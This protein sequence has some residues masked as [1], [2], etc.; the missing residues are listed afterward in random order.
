MAQLKDLL[1]TGAS[2]LLGDIYANKI[3]I[4]TINAPTT[5]AGTVYG[6]GNNGQVLKSDGSGVYWGVEN[7]SNIS[8]NSGTANKIAYYSG[9][10]T[11]SAASNL[12]IDNTITRLTTTSGTP[13]SFRVQSTDSENGS[14]EFGLAFSSDGST[15]GLYDYTSGAT[16]WYVS[17]NDDKKLVLKSE[18]KD[19]YLPNQ[20]SWLV[21]AGNGTSTG[22]GN[23]N[24]PVYV[25][26]A[27]IATAV[28]SINTTLIAAAS[29]AEAGL[30][31][32]DMVTK[33]NTIDT[34][35]NNYI[36]PTASNTVLGGVKIGSGLTISSTGVLSTTNN[37]A[38]YRG[39]NATATESAPA[40][41]DGNTYDFNSSTTLVG[42]IGFTS[43]ADPISPSSTLYGSLLSLPG[44]TS[45]SGY[46]AQLL[47]GSISGATGLIRLRARR[48]VSS[49]TWTPFNP[50][51][52]FNA[53]A[54]N[55]ITSNGVVIADGSIGGIKTSDIIVDAA[56]SAISATEYTISANGYNAT[57]TVSALGYDWNSLSFSTPDNNNIDT[58]AA[59][60]PDGIVR[61]QA[62]SSSKAQ[63]LEGTRPISAGFHLY[64]LEGYNSSYHH[65]F[66]LSSSKSIYHRFG[67]KNDMSSS[68][69][70]RFVTIQSTTT[71]SATTGSV[72]QW[73]AVGGATTPV[74]VSS[75]GNVVACNFSV[76]TSVPATAVFTDT[77]YSAATT[78]TDGLMTAAM[79]NQLNNFNN[80][81]L[82]TASSSV[83]GGVKIGSDLNI[84]NT[85]VLSVSH[86]A[87]ADGIN[88]QST[89]N[90]IACFSNTAGT[91]KSI[92]TA[93]GAAYATAAN[94]VLTFGTLPVTEGG[95]GLTAAPSL[96]VNLAVNT[97][98]NVFSA[99]PRPGVTG[100]L[101]LA[102]G[103]LG[104]TDVSVART[105]LGLG[106]LAIKDSL[107]ASDIPDIA[108]TK[109]TGT[110]MA[111]Q[112]P[113]IDL[114]S[115]V[116]GI[117][118]IKD[119][120]TSAS[121]PYVA[122]NNLN[123][124][125]VYK[126]VTGIDDTTTNT[127]LIY[128]DTTKTFNFSSTK[129]FVGA[130]GFSSFPH[131]VTGVANYGSLLALPGVATTGY[132]AELLLS[133]ISGA[134]NYPTLS[135]RRQASTGTWSPWLHIG[136]GNNG[137]VYCPTSSTTRAK[138]G[139]CTN[140]VLK[141][142]SYYMV[143][144]ENDNTYSS[145]YFTLNVNGTGAKR[146]YI[147]GTT[148]GTSNHTLPAGDYLVWYSGNYYYF[149]T[150]SAMEGDFGRVFGASG[151]AGLYGPTLPS[152]SEG[153]IFFQT[154][155]TT[156]PAV[157]QVNTIAATANSS[158][159]LIGALT[160]GVATPYIA[161]ANSNGTKNKN[162]VRFNGSTGVL[163]GAAWNDYAEFRQKKDIVDI[164]YG[165]VV[166]E[167]GDDTVSLSTERLQPCGQ[168]ISDTYGFILGPEENAL[169][170]A[171]CGRVLAYP[172]EDR[173][174]FD[175]GDAVCTG[176][177]GKVS[178]MTR[179]EIRLWPDRI[180]GYVSSIPSYEIWEEKD[181]KVNGRIWIKVK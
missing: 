123:G 34:N 48:Q 134:T 88:I 38:I 105:T 29:T 6:A 162:G 71:S 117:L 167:N 180:I 125:P 49:G 119:G 177:N 106:S 168:I 12:E 150:D 141:A 116:T 1:V 127:D 147:N 62:L 56:S 132:G 124:L 102:N 51:G 4:T 113:D 96:L 80:Y 14:K 160:D 140:F 28:T 164:P 136:A 76:G 104:T 90:G 27:G 63:S 45:N 83:L 89:T 39:V 55:E 79:V 30:M 126:G 173:N 139:I 163:L 181:I 128:N 43:F 58:I 129:T 91:V 9:E 16:G 35:A 151:T 84:S 179:E 11:I 57:S 68:V 176:P 149:N 40:T 61:Y 42:A 118:S 94:G 24:I 156:D 121:D 172:Y 142:H 46:G 59:S 67:P 157:G 3:Q 5:A 53:T 21:G 60:A 19:H 85:G 138:I 26:T 99:S 13:G 170:I 69:W 112:I 130:V 169:P 133:S 72:A 33:L 8:I 148:S 103:G 77:T 87:K 20:K 31:T 70:E 159:Y 81:S 111:A 2:R 17:W 131:P 101:G 152:G 74:Y 41:F 47:L 75:G 95:S 18:G 107:D 135:V 178:K 174:S 93:K 23:T 86:A 97:T 153:R 146:I 10:N 155:S 120:G 78:E 165:K 115:K 54:S 82:P 52:V 145:N 7:N 122:I 25:T 32:A 175:I 37:F 65:Q 154:T 100:V 143:H 137:I 114:A 108:A 50:I 36:L 22:A 161:T 109:I 66:L 64:H 15:R 92:A 158:Y 166:I 144:M 171:L 73:S 44:T 110:F 98:A